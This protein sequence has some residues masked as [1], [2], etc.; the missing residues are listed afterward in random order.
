MCRGWFST[1]LISISNNKPKQCWHSLINI[2]HSLLGTYWLHSCTSLYWLL[3][4]NVLMFILILVSITP[5]MHI[6]YLI[7]E[8]S[9][10]SIKEV[11]YL[12]HAINYMYLSVDYLFR[13]AQEINNVRMFSVS[14]FHPCK[15]WLDGLISWIKWKLTCNPFGSHK[16]L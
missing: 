9:N 10:L 1:P 14:E 7:L 15:A 8:H 3:N 16:S 11:S 4:I 2:Q 13:S 6:I 12:S 5:C